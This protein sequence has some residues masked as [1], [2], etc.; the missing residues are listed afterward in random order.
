MNSN[1]WSTKN[2]LIAGFVGYSADW[3]LLNQSRICLRLR[4]PLGHY[5]H[6]IQIQPHPRPSPSYLVILEA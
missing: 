4:D 6:F 1:F 5:C 3:Q 2:Y